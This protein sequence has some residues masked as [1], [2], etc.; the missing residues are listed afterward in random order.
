MK[1]VKI[2]N[3]LIKL[4]NKCIGYTG[5]YVPPTPP[6]GNYDFRVRVYVPNDVQQIAVN[7]FCLNRDYEW[8]ATQCYSD[9]D[10]NNYLSD[11]SEWN[12]GT[13][14]TYLNVIGNDS[15]GYYA[16]FYVTSDYASEVQAGTFG[17]LILAVY[18]SDDY[19]WTLC[20]MKIWNANDVLVADETISNPHLDLWVQYYYF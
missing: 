10:C 6:L 18:S 14:D 8:N 17:T 20:K 19:D 13:P 11:L 2:N 9:P 5:P 15:N 16:E 1:L 4:N 12:D 7:T 3:S